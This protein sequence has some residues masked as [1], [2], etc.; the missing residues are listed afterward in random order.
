[1]FQSGGFDST[2]KDVEASMERYFIW[3]F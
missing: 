3:G 2:S 1:L